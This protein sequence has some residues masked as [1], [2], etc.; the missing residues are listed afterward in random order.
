M[1]DTAIDS[2]TPVYRRR[3]TDKTRTEDLT[4]G[5]FRVIKRDGGVSKFDLERITGAVTKAFLAVKPEGLAD[6][7][8]KTHDAVFKIA[9]DVFD[10]LKQRIPD[11]GTFH[12]EDVQDQVELSIMRNNHI[13]VGRAYIFYRNSHSEIRKAEATNENTADKDQTGVL[14]TIANG[15]KPL[16]I[17]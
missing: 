14:A 2:R 9:N 11:G 3:A 15:E 8:Q 16:L 17:K 12:I 4:P 6:S 1:S 7:S 5:Q 13:A 10:A